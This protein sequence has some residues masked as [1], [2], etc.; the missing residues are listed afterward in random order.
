LGRDAHVEAYKKLG[1]NS[2]VYSVS[3]FSDR[4]ENKE[5]LQD[6]LGRMKND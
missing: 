3:R 2:N 1:E 4:E 6:L 5:K